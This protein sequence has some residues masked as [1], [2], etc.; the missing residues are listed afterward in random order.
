MKGI[1]V[2][3]FSLC[4]SLSFA[5]SP[6]EC[7]KYVDDVLSLVLTSP[8]WN[9][10]LD[11][12]DTNE[13]EVLFPTMASVFACEMPSNSCGFAWSAAEREQAWGDFLFA[14]SQ[15]N[16]AFVADDF[17]RTG[18]YAFLCC[19]EKQY[20][21]VLDNA[22]RVLS[23]SCAPC[24]DAAL[25]YLART[26]VPSDEMTMAIVGVQTNKFDFSKEVRN[27][28][29]SA[30]V[31]KLNSLSIIDY[32]VVTNAARAI[33]GERAAIDHLRAVDLLLLNT[34]T[35]YANSSN[36]L[37]V[38]NLALARVNED[39]S[40]VESRLIRDYFIPVTNQLMNAQQPLSDVEALRGL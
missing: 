24:K 21:N 3:L 37:V 40:S 9:D 27:Q 36:R 31:E 10:C 12:A 26:A 23:S 28:T 2:V 33:Y 11:E 13:V 14:L 6:E 15:T 30:Y 35:N 34:W 22:L 8:E 18:S 29:M 20:T 16:R 38:A 7:Y 39:A 25:E 32:L 5:H 1:L 19:S 4:T 17:I